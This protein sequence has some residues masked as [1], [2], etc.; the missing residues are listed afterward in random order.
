MICKS[1]YFEEKIMGGRREASFCK[2]NPS[3]Q[4]EK[5]TMV[6]FLRKHYHA[7]RQRA[8]PYLPKISTTMIIS[9]RGEVD[10]Q[11]GNATKMEKDGINWV[12]YWR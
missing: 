1:N 5:G 7:V 9:T 8:R 11:K 12:A 10:N 3:L 2:T 6:L 4:V